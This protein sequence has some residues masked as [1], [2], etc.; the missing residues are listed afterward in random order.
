MDKWVL[1]KTNPEMGQVKESYMLYKQF[2]LL[3]VPEDKIDKQTKQINKHLEHCL[4]NKALKT[5]TIR[6]ETYNN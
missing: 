3:M 2:L 6:S 1:P 5:L 4:V